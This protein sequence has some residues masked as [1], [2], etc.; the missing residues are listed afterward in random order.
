MGSFCGCERVGG[1]A[2]GY[3][4][5]P[6]AKQRQGAKTEKP[7]SRLLVHV[8]GFT[9]TRC[10]RGLVA[11]AA[12]RQTL[13]AN[14]IQVQVVG[15]GRYLRQARDLA[16]DLGL[17]FTFVRREEGGPQHSAADSQ[18]DEQSKHYGTALL[19]DEQ[20]VVHYRQQFRYPEEPIDEALLIGALRRVRSC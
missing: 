2:I 18:P 11:L 4:L 14:N 20:G 15:D 3:G 9:C 13:R 8:C 7:P 5:W 19:I 1:L 17:P 6:L 12:S 16:A 10:W